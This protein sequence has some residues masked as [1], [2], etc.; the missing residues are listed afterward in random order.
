MPA[1]LVVGVARHRS[2][3]GM[4]L[5]WSKLPAAI[6]E[7]LS[8]KIREH[9]SAGIEDLRVRGRLPP[10]VVSPV[11]LLTLDLGEDMLE[12]EIENITSFS[13]ETPSRSA[14]SV[15]DVVYRGNAVVALRCQVQANPIT[16]RQPVFETLIASRPL[17]MP[18]S[19][20][21]GGLRLGG[22]I[23]LGI[24]QTCV[25][26]IVRSN[27]FHGVCFHSN[28]EPHMLAVHASLKRNL[29]RAVVAASERLVDHAFFISFA[30]LSTDQGGRA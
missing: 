18:L 5:Q 30:H 15:V 1:R 4:A 25:R 26:V 7:E 12:T 6:R 27:L 29:L 8:A 28:F 17:V 16:N 20:E 24:Q 19:L 13:P 9:V 2:S 21:L 3:A 22:K 11:E 14:E 23:Q 10:E